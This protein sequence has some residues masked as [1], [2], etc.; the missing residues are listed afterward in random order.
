MIAQQAHGELPRDERRA[1]RQRRLI[2]D[3]ATSNILQ[4][5]AGPLDDASREEELRYVDQ[6]KAPG[7]VVDSA[8]VA[9]AADH[10]APEETRPVSVLEAPVVRVLRRQD[11]RGSH[12]QYAGAPE[13]KP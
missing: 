13:K 1:Q 5:V 6:R 3:L 10:R 4:P 12:R 8:Q 11:A 2:Q 7:V 9:V